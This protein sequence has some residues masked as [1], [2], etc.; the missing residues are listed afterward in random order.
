MKLLMVCWAVKRVSMTGFTQQEIDDL[1]VVIEPPGGD[2]DPYTH[3]VGWASFAADN[4]PSI[5]WQG[6]KYDPHPYEVT[7]LELSDSGP[8]PTPTLYV[9]ISLTTSRRSVCS[10]TTW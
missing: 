10:M 2:D 8:Q 4:L 6:N 1:L 7:G 9:G 5:I 3:S